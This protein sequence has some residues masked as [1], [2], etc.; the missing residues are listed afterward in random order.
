MPTTITSAIVYFA[1]NVSRL[2][3]YR[4]AAVLLAAFG[5]GRTLR[6]GGP[7]D[8]LFDLGL[9]VVPLIVSA[10][11]FAGPLG[12][13]A[14]LGIAGLGAALAV[15]PT[16]E[17][18]EAAGRRGFP[19]PTAPGALLTV[20]GLAAAAC[21]GAFDVCPVCG[22]T[23]FYRFRLFHRGLGLAIVGGAAVS[24]LVGWTWRRGIPFAL[25]GATFADLLL[26]WIAPEAIACYKCKTFFEAFPPNHSIRPLD[27]TVELRYEV[28]AGRE[29][30]CP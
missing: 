20:A 4:G 22:R 13:P 9:G 8:P 29:R 2:R 25:L 24:D 30:P 6:R 10:F 11:G 27:S 14:A 3:G 12:V 7:V 15:R 21:S 19:R 23:D 1:D 26:S 28:E 17:W 18:I 5:Y 16:R